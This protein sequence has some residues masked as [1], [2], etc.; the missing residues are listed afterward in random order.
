MKKTTVFSTL[1]LIHRA[2]LTGQLIFTAIVFYLVYSKTML[3]ALAEHDKILQ[4]IALAFTIV[5]IIVGTKLFKKKL[6]LI[7]DESAG[8]AKERL[9]KY[10]TASM[11]LWGLVELPCLVCGICLLLTGNYAFLA[12]SLVVTLYYALLMPV[13]DRIAQQLNLSNTELNEL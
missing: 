13:K 3:P 7:K 6:V 10:R 12:L 2:M 4:T 5:A 1:S 11:L 9:V 8:D